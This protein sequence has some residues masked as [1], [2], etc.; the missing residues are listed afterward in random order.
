MLARL[1]FDLASLIDEMLLHI[2][3]QFWKSKKTTFSDT[4]MGG[5]Q[6][7]KKVIE[8]LKLAGHDDLNIKNRIYGY[9][10]NE[11]YLEYVTAD[12]NIIG[13]FDVYNENINMNNIIIL[14]R[15]LHQN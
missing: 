8:K 10:E 2:P 7:I 3:I 6:F 15:F 4:H 13:K 1:K 11:M 5:G 9:S 12:E 14:G